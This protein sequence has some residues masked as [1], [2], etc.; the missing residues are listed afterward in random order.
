MSTDGLPRPRRAYELLPHHT[1]RCYFKLHLR[2]FA[3][4]HRHNSS[5]VARES[6]RLVRAEMPAGVGLPHNRISPQ[7]DSVRA[8]ERIGE[9]GHG[10]ER[11]RR[12]KLVGVL[13]VS[14]LSGSLPKP[15]VDTV[16]FRTRFSTLADDVNVLP[17]REWR[18]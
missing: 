3:R 6:I 13:P 8:G 14:T 18:R 17:S 2:M 16:P 11:A 1:V 9:I 12:P 15:P 4:E 5:V 7:A 10:V